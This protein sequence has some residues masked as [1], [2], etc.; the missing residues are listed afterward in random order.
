MTMLKKVVDAVTELT[1]LNRK[2]REIEKRMDE[3]KEVIRPWAKEKFLAD[4]V[5]NPQLTMIEIPSSQG[6]CSVVFPRDTA[7]IVKGTSP[8]IIKPKLPAEKWNLLF[9][10]TVVL[11]DSFRESWLAAQ[12]TFTKAERNLVLKVVTFQE[13][14]PRVEPAK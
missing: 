5:G 13:A 11:S 7:S 10:D 2:K 1:V 4:R 14:T 12:S 9:T 3:L 6:T 8:N